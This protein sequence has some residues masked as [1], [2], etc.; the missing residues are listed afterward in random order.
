MAILTQVVP[1]K[2]EEHFDDKD[3]E[4]IGRIISNLR[5]T[6]AERLHQAQAD[7]H[8]AVR[9]MNQTSHEVARLERHLQRIAD[10]CEKNDIT[11][12]DKE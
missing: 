7:Y 2:Y 12:E 10:F 1:T 3:R 8:Q 5:D 9:R 11:I 4:E 6:Y